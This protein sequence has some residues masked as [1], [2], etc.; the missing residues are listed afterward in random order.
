MALD[1]IMSSM[2]WRAMGILV[3]TLP[4]ET[5]ILLIHTKRFL[6]LLVIATHPQAIQL[7]HL[8]SEWAGKPTERV[9]IEAVY[10]DAEEEAGE[11]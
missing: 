9:E 3:T 8:S 6:V 5:A 4:D 1:E 2:S 7:G 11:V 10:E